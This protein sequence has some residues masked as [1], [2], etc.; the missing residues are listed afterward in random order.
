MATNWLDDEQQRIWRTF[1]R[2]TNRIQQFL[3]ADLR[4]FGLTLAEYE[5]LTNLSESE[6]RRLRMSDLA[7]AVHQSRSRLT[8]TV[9][10]LEQAGHVIRTTCAADGRGV[11]AELTEPGFEFLVGVAPHHVDAVRRIL[12]DAVEPAD[13]VALGR[14]MDAVCS[15]AD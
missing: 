15:V 2:G 7:D 6:G 1:L 4:R 14:A 13:F 11:W 8:H 10:R 12:V 9:T 5:I 3:D